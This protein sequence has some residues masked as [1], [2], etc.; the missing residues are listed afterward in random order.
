MTVIPTIAIRLASPDDA[1]QILGIYAPFCLDTPVTFEIEPPS[2]ETMRLR[3]ATTLERHPWLVAEREGRVL[4]YVYAGPHHE[5]VA[6]QWS[7]NVAV[8]VNETAR[9]TGVARALY[10]KLFDV[11]ARQG[12]CNAFAIITLPNPASAGAHEA[13]GFTKVGHFPRAGYKCGQWHDV[14]WWHR[15]LR[16]HPTGPTPP[17]LLPDL[18][19]VFD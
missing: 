13:L 9:R 16:E 17:I 3:I 6:Y 11:L 1:E 10:T 5:R 19:P 15:P 14:G 2:L 12:H 7:V 8:Y 4:G 18:A